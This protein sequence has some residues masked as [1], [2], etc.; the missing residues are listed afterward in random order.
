MQDCTSTLEDPAD[1]VEA[2]LN[3]YATVAILPDEP[4][5]PLPP[6]TTTTTTAGEAPGTTEG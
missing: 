3:G 4:E 5:T 6:E 1:D 2:F